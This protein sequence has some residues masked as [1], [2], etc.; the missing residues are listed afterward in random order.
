[1]GTGDDP[2]WPSSRYTPPPRP[3]NHGQAWEPDDD[4]VL[5]H[6]WLR[7]DADAVRGEVLQG[8]ADRLGRTVGAVMQRLYRVGCEPSRLGVAITVPPGAPAPPEEPLIAT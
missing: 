2:W 6:T 1:M 4:A 8:L 5:R 7:A 3:R